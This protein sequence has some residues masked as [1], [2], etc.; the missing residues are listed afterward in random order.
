MTASDPRPFPALPDTIDD[1]HIIGICGSA[2]G[3]LAAMLQQKGYRVRGSDANAYPPMSTWLADRDIDIM[4]GYDAS[5]LDWDPDLV[6]VGNVCRESYADAVE[7]RRRKLPHL[8]LPEALRHFV[9]DDKRPLVLTG[10]HGKTTTTSMLAWIL[11]HAGA[12]PGFM[13]G[14]IAG[15]FGTNYRLGDGKSFVIEGDEYDT[16]YFDK[17]PKFWHYAPFRA[18]INNLEFDHADI[19]PDLEAIEAVFERFVAMIPTEGSLWINGDD[20]NLEGLPSHADCSVHTF[21]LHAANDLHP[22][23]WHIEDGHTVADLVLHGESLGTLRIPTIGDF[24]LR[25]AMGATAIALDEGIEFNAIA[26]ALTQFQPAKKRQQLIDTV[27]DIAVYD[28]FAH[29]PTAV[30][31]T[32]TA[33]RDQLDDPGA[34]LWALFEATSN[35][36]RRRVFQDAYPPAFAPADEVI[37]ASPREKSDNLSAD[38]RIDVETLRSDIAEAGPQTRLIPDV[39]DIVDTVVREAR[40]GDLVVGLSGASFGD[41]HHKLVQ[42]LKEKR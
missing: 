1:I 20:S 40:P 11:T 27:D 25:N 6:I 26:D 29:H 36:S 21:G 19:Y 24:N 30:Q 8:S 16:A 18:T 28:D 17:V 32:L 4:V 31:A 38:E 2:M 10:T 13:L 5:N 22:R 41:I 35:T 23:Q 39:D 37:I 12:D 15:N 7:M 34:R 3:S 33:F 9:F 14:G 42:A